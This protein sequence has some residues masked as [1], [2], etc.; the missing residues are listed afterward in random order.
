M[1]LGADGEKMSKSRGNVINPNELVEKYGADALRLAEIFLGPPEQTTNFNVKSV[2]L[3]SGCLV[4]TPERQQNCELAV[5]RIDGI[6]TNLYFLT[7]YTEPSKYIREEVKI[8]YK[9]PQAQKE[10]VLI[11]CIDFNIG[12]KIA[13]HA[14]LVVD[15][16]Q[17]LKKLSEIN[18]QV[19]FDFIQKYVNELQENSETS[20]FFA[21]KRIFDLHAFSLDLVL[22]VNYLPLVVLVFRE[23]KQKSFQAVADYQ[24]YLLQLYKYNFFS[25]LRT[26]TNDFVGVITDEITNYLRK[27]LARY[28]QHSCSERIL[29]SI[30]EQKQKGGSLTMAFSAA[31]I[32]SEYPQSTI[33]LITDRQELDRQLYG[34]FTDFPSLL[35]SENI[36]PVSSV[37]E[38]AV[39]LRKSN[40][41]KII[42]IILHK[43]RP[44][45]FQDWLGKNE[46]EF[47]NPHGTFV[48]VDEAHRSQNLKIQP[49]KPEKST[50]TEFGSSLEPLHSYSTKEAREDQVIVSNIYYEPCRFRPTN[51]LKQMIIKIKKD[52]E[53]LSK[54][55]PSPKFLVTLSSQKEAKQFY[56]LFCQEEKHQ[57]VVCLII[58]EVP[59]NKETIRK[60]KNNSLPNIAVVVNMLATGFDLPVLRH[61]YIG[62]KIQTINKKV[63]HIID[64]ADNNSVLEAAKKNYFGSENLLL[65]SPAEAIASCLAELR[66]ILS[67]AANLN[68]NYL[69]K[70]K[71][72]REFTRLVRKIE[73]IIVSPQQIADTDQIFFTN[74]QKISASL[75]QFS[76][77]PSSPPSPPPPVLPISKDDPIDEKNPRDIYDEGHYRLFILVEKIMESK[78]KEIQENLKKDPNYLVKKNCEDY[79]QTNFP[80]FFAKNQAKLSGFLEK[81]VKFF[82][83]KFHDD[84]DWFLLSESHGT[85]ELKKMV[86]KICFESFALHYPGTL[87]E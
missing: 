18:K 32:L 81:I 83:E 74:C 71:K 66:Q 67:S 28:Y 84:P 72:E 45:K 43:F 49:E 30:K 19:P 64:F 24:K 2:L 82:S 56:E 14:N 85:R 1:I 53:E 75:T 27:I 15:E 36:I 60:F 13:K 9:L 5:E 57:E 42:F 79:L 6:L 23:S 86:D 59:N 29:T 10:S 26:P 37:R 7:E 63:G 4:L 17:L 58:S 33:F 47:K 21:N 35:N 73:E 78:Y 51:D 38:L 34:F 12:D 44:Q 68:I 70:N 80:H 25:V 20:L 65:I 87:Q 39:V 50:Y 46:K 61:I 8:E 76:D 69:L 31:R 62:K 16:N 54:K 22:F 77:P 3:V 52:Y 11:S 55:I 40:Q 48:F 41:G